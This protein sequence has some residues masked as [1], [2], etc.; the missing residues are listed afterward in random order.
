MCIR[1]IPYCTC[2]LAIPYN[3]VLILAIVYHT[4]LYL[5]AIPYNTV[6]TYYR[7]I[8]FTNV[9]KYNTLLHLLVCLLYHT[10][11]YLPARPHNTVL[12]CYTIQ[13]CILN[14]GFDPNQ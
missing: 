5:L 3:T 4:I 7:T 6:L 10:I 14:K 9:Y 11:L 8:R 2:F 12:T 1:I 13:C